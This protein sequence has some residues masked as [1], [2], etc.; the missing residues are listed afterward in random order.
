MIHGGTHFNFTSGANLADHYQPVTTS[1]DYDSAI[2][3]AGDLTEKFYLIKEVI[4]KVRL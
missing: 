3:E 4:K 1:Y 2:S